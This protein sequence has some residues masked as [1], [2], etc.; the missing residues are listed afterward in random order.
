MLL[1]LWLWRFNFLMYGP[2]YIHVY[3]K[4][5]IALPVVLCYVSLTNLDVVHY[6][7]LENGHWWHPKLSVLLLPSAYIHT[8]WEL[9]YCMMGACMHTFLFSMH[10][11]WYKNIFTI[12]LHRCSTNKFIYLPV[13]SEI[14]QLASIKFLSWMLHISFCETFILL[15]GTVCMKDR[16]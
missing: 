1:L 9:Y 3:S 8:K 2:L 12:I 10:L 14:S 5:P 6:L 16:N 4:W 7:F 15:I 13:I 11:K